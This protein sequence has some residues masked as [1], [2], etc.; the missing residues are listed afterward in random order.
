M[1][2]PDEE[3]EVTFASVPN[4]CQ[5]NFHLS[6]TEVLHYLLPADKCHVRIQSAR[7]VCGAEVELSFVMFDQRVGNSLFCAHEKFNYEQL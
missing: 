6:K 3:P 7:G 2:L 4:I 1:Y 5:K